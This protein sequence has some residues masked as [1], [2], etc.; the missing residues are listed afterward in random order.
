MSKLCGLC[1]VTTENTD[2]LGCH[3]VCNSFFHLKCLAEKNSLYTLQLINILRGI[4]Q[5]HW[6][7]DPC[8]HI[9]LNGVS[10]KIIDSA[11]I[12]KDAAPF[13]SQLPRLLEKLSLTNS[14]PAP[15]ETNDITNG[16]VDAPQLPLSQNASTGSTS[17]ISLVK[18]NTLGSLCRDSNMQAAKKRKFNDVSVNNSP[19]GING[20]SSALSSVTAPPEMVLKSV[21][22][23]KLP[24]VTDVAHIFQHLAD[25]SIDTTLVKCVRLVKKWNKK[26]LSFVS[27]K[28]DA[29]P[30]IFEKIVLQSFW[31]ENLIIKEFVPIVKQQHNKVFPKG[32]GTKTKQKTKKSKQGTKAKQSMKNV[33]S[34][35]VN[36]K[37][38]TNRWQVVRLQGRPPKNHQQLQQQQS[39]QQ[40]HQQQQMPFPMQ[41]LSMNQLYSPYNWMQMLPL[42]NRFAPMMQ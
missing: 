25:S 40:F 37:R 1:A 42:Q 31:P 26:K 35:Q 4:G 7:C 20:T 8:H 32:K 12:L 2:A 33:K 23:S 41:Q 6:Y 19:V 36:Q 29:P 24:P 11:K 15:M 13:L 27:F 9:T 10:A 14:L 38:A 3:G 28:I 21:Y 18:S 34:K 22:V 17:L 16:V 5:L 30:D 39:Q